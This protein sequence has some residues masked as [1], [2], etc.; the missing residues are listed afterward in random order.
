[1][2]QP[3]GM[4]IRKGN[5]RRTTCHKLYDLAGPCH[6]DI[7]LIPPPPHPP[8]VIDI[9]AFPLHSTRP[10]MTK[11]S[12]RVCKIH[13]FISSV[14]GAAAGRNGSEIP[15]GGQVATNIRRLVLSYTNKQG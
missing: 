12:S 6:T 7:L 8:L 14:A 5:G 1:M 2:C 13:K 3:A 4:Y 9:R 10:P 15:R 11:S